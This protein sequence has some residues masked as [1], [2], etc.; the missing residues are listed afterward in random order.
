VKIWAK[1]H[2]RSDIMKKKPM[3]IISST[4]C[5]AFIIFCISYSIALSKFSDKKRNVESGEDS[6]DSYV[7]LSKMN[8]TLSSETNIVL[9]LKVKNIKDDFTVKTIK[10]SDLNNVIKDRLSLKEV[11]SYYNGLYY[12]LVSSSEKELVF[13]KES[14]FEP[15]KYYLGANE[16]YISILKCNSEGQL[17]LEEPLSDRSNTKL[18]IL[19]ASDREL[20]S[21]YEFKFENREEALDELASISS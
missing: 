20:I 21:N 2:I 4:L 10:V 6:K 9:K 3:I 11:E 14:K 17:F 13:V 18:D 16:G 12:N 19:P 5:L 8:Q 7:T 1:C 15:N